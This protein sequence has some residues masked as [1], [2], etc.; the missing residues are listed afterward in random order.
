MST[1]SRPL[2]S[3][4]PIDRKYL[5]TARKPMRVLFGVVFVS[6]CAISTVIGVQDHLSP[7]AWSV[8]PIIG[9]VSAG[10]AIGLAVAAAIFI[11]E[12]LLAERSL[13]WY[14]LLLGIDAYYTARWSS[15]IGELI[16][17]HMGAD[18]LVED[19]VSFVVT[20]A[21]AIAIAYLGEHLIFDRRR[22]VSRE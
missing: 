3:G 1:H 2:T 22:S 17:A 5:D 10:L 9:S 6:Y 15:W 19:V 20:W 8:Q 21:A 16:H 14:V 7:L 18:A 13:G 12:V 4:A 11:G